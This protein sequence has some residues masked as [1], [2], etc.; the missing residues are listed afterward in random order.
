MHQSLGSKAHRTRK[1]CFRNADKCISMK[2][3]KKY[4][5][6]NTIRILIAKRQSEYYE[7]GMRKSETTRENHAIRGSLLYRKSFCL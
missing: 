5:G 6:F 3:F 4:A 7:V 2:K 1:K